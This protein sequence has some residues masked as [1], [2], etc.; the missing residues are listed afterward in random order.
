MSKSRNC[1]SCAL[2]PTCTYLNTF[3]IDMNMGCMD[4]TDKIVKTIATSGSSN[5]YV[6]PTVASGTNCEEANIVIDT[7]Y[8]RG[9]R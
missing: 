6:K 5:H 7:Q 2:F 4:W 1:Y 8:E 9:D 3:N